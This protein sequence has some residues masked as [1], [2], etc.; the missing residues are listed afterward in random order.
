MEEEGLGKSEVAGQRQPP[1]LL[2][3][4][5]ADKRER[6]DREMPKREWFGW[7]FVLERERK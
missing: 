2:E 4:E 6:E 7:P 1:K 3:N 5:H